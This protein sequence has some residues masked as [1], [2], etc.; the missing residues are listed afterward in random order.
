MKNFESTTAI[1]ND[2]NEELAKIFDT[3]SNFLKGLMVFA[4]VQYVL[5]LVIL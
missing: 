2:E 4:V 1:T 5:F 3:Q